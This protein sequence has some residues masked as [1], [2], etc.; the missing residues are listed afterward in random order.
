MMGMTIK[1]IGGAK[2]E[3]QQETNREGRN[4]G[5]NTRQL[6]KHVVD[7]NRPEHSD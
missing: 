6:F 2:G 4:C 3:D 1:N 5:E 7:Y